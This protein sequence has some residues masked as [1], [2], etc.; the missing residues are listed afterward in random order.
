MPE[1]WSDAYGQAL[2]LN[3]PSNEKWKRVVAQMK[4]LREEF[5]SFT[6]DRRAPEQSK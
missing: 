6:R 5:E 4:S 1:M 2:I 3:G